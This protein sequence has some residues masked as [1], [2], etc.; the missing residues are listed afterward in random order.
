MLLFDSPEYEKFFNPLC[1][2]NKRIYYECI[3]LLIEKSKQVTLLY[4]NDARDSLTL[5]FR[6]LAYA[7][8]DEEGENVDEATLWMDF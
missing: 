3:N 4:E 7:V 1:C 2:K 6:N 8:I 5:Y